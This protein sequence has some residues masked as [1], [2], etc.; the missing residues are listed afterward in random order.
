MERRAVVFRERLILGH[1]LVLSVLVVRTS[2]LQ[3]IISIKLNVRCLKVCSG[4][5]IACK[6][7]DGF[8][9][10]FDTSQIRFE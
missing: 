9:G 2:K 8:I 5:P 10:T 6:T 7:D 1:C 3:I 4:I